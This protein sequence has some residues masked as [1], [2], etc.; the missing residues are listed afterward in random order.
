MV[1]RPAV[2]LEMPGLD[3]LFA[4]FQFYVITMAIAI[5]YFKF[6]IHFFRHFYGAAC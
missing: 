5:K 2:F 1:I 3:N 6:A 4:L